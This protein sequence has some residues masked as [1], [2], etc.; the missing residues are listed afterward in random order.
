MKT[1]AIIGVGPGLGLSIARQFGKQGFRV[2]LIARTQA[3][4]DACTQ[5]LQEQGI[6][7]AGFRADIKDMAQLIATFAHI[8]AVFG[9]LDILTYSHGPGGIAEV[10]SVLDLTH[11][12]IQEQLHLQMHGALT[13]V[14]AILP[15]MQ[16]RGS[17]AIF[18]ITGVSSVTPNANLADVGI[19]MSALRNYA[20]CL[21]DAL[22]D[23]G[24][25]VGHFAVGTWIAKGAEGDPDILAARIADM[26]EKRDRVEEVF[27]PR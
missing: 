13:S 14:Q 11:N 5:Q 17:G 18:F 2:A 3:N 19:A 20:H 12:R 26:Y 8:K 9:A 24:I 25:Y 10:T 4:L 7:A 22:S 6:E 27:L 1:I 15:D 16:A 23:K 21:H